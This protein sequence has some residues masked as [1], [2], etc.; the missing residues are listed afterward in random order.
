MSRLRSRWAGHPR[1]LRRSVIVAVVGPGLVT[2]LALLEARVP[3]TTAAMLYVLVV[4]VCSAI[5]GGAAGLG[6]SLLSFLALNFFFTPPFHTLVV[7]RSQ[8]LIALVAFLVV[9]VITGL[10]LST[11]LTEKA[12]AERREIQTRLLNRFTSRLLKGEPLEVVLDDF[13]EKLAELFGFARVEIRTVMTEP[14]T[15]MSDPAVEAGKQYRMELTSKPGP[16]GELVVT[17]PASNATLDGDEH[18]VLRGFAGQLALALESVRLSDEVRRIQLE[19]ETNRLRATLFSGVTHDLKTPL[20]A[21][22]ASVTSLLDGAGFSRGERHEHLEMIRQEAEHLNRV[23]SNLLDLSRLRAG[24]LIP[25]TTRASIDEPIEA[26]VARLQPLLHDRDVNIDLRGR[27]PEVAVDLVQINQV[28][29]NLIENAAKFSPPRSPIDIS[30]VG[31]PSGV[32]VTV[33]DRGPGIPKGVRDRV[34][35]PFER[36][37]VKK[38]GTGLGLAISKAVI[39]AH[40]G[41]IWASEAP[42]GG[43]VITFELPI[44]VGEQVEWNPMS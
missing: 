16:V 37:D 23:V 13:A 12:R 40:G 25:S 20:S 27:L 28:L 33:T 19:A 44:D 1:G 24:V 8:D 32:R 42:G 15:F 34:F 3:S 29:T 39:V 22:T 38:A 9:S 30:A 10:L 2:L 17:T 18:S 14:V 31:S 35:E 7:G 21:I 11:A 4:A 26:V 6:A 5:G 41:R 43:A 36:G